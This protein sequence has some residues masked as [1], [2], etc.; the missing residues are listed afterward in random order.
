MEFLE[1]SKKINESSTKNKETE[2]LLEKENKKE[3]NTFN[4]IKKKLFKKSLIKNIS[5]S[6]S[7]LNK[8]SKKRNEAKLKSIFQ[9]SQEQKRNR[10]FGIDIARIIAIILIINHH[11]L[12]HGGPLFHTKNLSFE[13][14][15]F[16]YFN[17]IFTSGVNIFGMISGFV[18]FPSHKFS[19]L[20][21]LLFQTFFYN[22]G[23]AF[24]FKKTKP[25]YVHDLR[26]FLYPLFISDY[27]YI[28]AYCIIYFFFPSINIGIK[29][30]EKR[31]MG[32]FNLSLF[33]FFSCFSQIKHY[34]TRLKGDYFFFNNGLS[35]TWLL[36]LYFLGSYFGRFYKESHNYNKFLIFVL[37]LGII[38]IATFY[39]TLIVINK[40]KQQH[41]HSFNM[42][43]EYTSPSSVIISTCIIIMFSKVDIKSNILQRIISFFAPLT[44]GVYLI[45]NHKLVRENIIAKNYSW[46]LKYHSIKLI[47]IQVFESIKIFLFCSL[48]DFFRL[49]IFKIL[50]IKQLSIFIS[51]LLAKMGNGILCIFEFLY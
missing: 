3:Y 37:C 21:Y 51:N 9:K 40:I 29:T 33:L 31:Q 25:K 45:H 1:N 49:L 28:S 6:N 23:I 34:S 12:F 43:Y 30:M 46:L 4:K 48:I 27:W 22:Y 14:Y 24:Y 41:K 38:C 8:K 19:N 15:L 26:R 32:I 16:I 13:K 18:G 50:R 17:Y 5:T 44:F 10:H 42:I 7:L 36:I 39:R 47:I 2:A 35:F 20:I 11:I